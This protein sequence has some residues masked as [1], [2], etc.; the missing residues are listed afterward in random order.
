MRIMDALKRMFGI[1]GENTHRAAVI[2]AY[3]EAN[4]RESRALN[5]QLRAYQNEK[6][7]FMAL[8]TDLHNK[9][10]MSDAGHSSS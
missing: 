6:D 1:S 9:R 2:E 3:A 4:I 10:A 5:A 8:V 7:P